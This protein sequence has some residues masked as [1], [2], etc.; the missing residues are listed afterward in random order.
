[1]KRLNRE[2]WTALINL[3]LSSFALLFFVYSCGLIVAA[4]LF[5]YAS[6]ITKL[7]K[8]AAERL[9]LTRKK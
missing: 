9:N 3:T 5:C 6:G 4:R 8:T 2:F 1:M 7:T